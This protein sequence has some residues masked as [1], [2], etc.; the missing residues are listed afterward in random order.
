MKLI[1]FFII[2]CG[3][4]QLIWRC[5]SPKNRIFVAIKINFYLYFNEKKVM[6]DIAIVKSNEF[7]KIEP[8]ILGSTNILLII[9]YN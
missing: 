6:L 4:L 1:K 3:C 7:M 8:H 5:T 2:I 9:E